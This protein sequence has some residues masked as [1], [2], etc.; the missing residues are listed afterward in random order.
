MLS[1][2]S[3]FANQWYASLGEGH[4][5]SLPTRDTATFGNNVVA[6]PNVQTDTLG[7]C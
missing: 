3:S 4:A 6:T 2:L 5:T 7:M 1:L